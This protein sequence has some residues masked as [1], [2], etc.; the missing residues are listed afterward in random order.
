M[1]GHKNRRLARAKTCAQV[2]AKA[3]AAG[4]TPDEAHSCAHDAYRVIRE[5]Q[6]PGG[7]RAL[8]KNVAEFG[9]VGGAVLGAVG[10]AVG[11]IAP[12][13]TVIGAAAAAAGA[14]LAAAGKKQARDIAHLKETKARM[15][16]LTAL[17]ASGSTAMPNPQTDP[18]GVGEEKPT[19]ATVLALKTKEKKVKPAKQTQE[20][21]PQT[22]PQSE[23][24]APM[25]MM[26][27]IM[28]GIKNFFAG[29]GGVK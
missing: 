21:K 6:L 14:G 25:G 7:L 29:I 11:T 26:E 1:A 8:K 20:D 17:V 10:A 23:N 13:G 15:Q 2:E 18:L 4:L 24:P 28:S 27:K 22:L 3:L 12:I 9:Q 16:A 19:P 5:K